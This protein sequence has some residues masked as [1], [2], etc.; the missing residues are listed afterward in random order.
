MIV[1]GQSEVFSV[2]GSISDDESEEGHV[3]RFDAIEY[4]GHVWL[5]PSWLE[6]P[7]GTHR[8]PE[9]IVRLDSEMISSAGV[10]PDVRYTLND[11]VPKPVLDG[12]ALQP[13]GYVVVELPNIR[14]Q[15]ASH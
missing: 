7:E 13:S 12:S 3:I 10:P 14:V 1:L 11:P 8:L 5:V 4:E 9:R 15:L 6:S 2:L